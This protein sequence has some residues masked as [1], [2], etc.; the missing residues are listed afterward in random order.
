MLKWP[1]F[2][3]LCNSVLPTLYPCAPFVHF[4]YF[5]RTVVIL[6]VFPG[7]L[8]VT[9][10]WQTF[11]WINQR[12]CYKLNVAEMLFVTQEDSTSFM[13]DTFDISHIIDQVIYRSLKTFLAQCHSRCILL[14]WYWAQTRRYCPH[15]FLL[16]KHKTWFQIRRHRCRPG[17]QWISDGD[18][19]HRGSGL[20]SCVVVRCF[21]GTK[22][23]TVNRLFVGMS[24]L[25]AW[26]KPES[27]V[28]LWCL[29][30]SFFLAVLSAASSG[31]G[32]GGVST[33]AAKARAR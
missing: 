17:L 13:R 15:S 18:M 14:C 9:W 20:T 21:H 12:R 19:K 32:D 5:D 10:L 23:I 2:K 24:K 27:Y 28:S 4:R 22:H 29:V 7:C 3:Y 8:W 25:Y 11:Y 33:G 16:Q 30:P 6:V 26:R 31:R 1:V